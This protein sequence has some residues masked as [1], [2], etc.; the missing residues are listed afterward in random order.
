MSSSVS[1]TCEDWKVRVPLPLN[2]VVLV[3]AHGEGAEDPHRLV[4]EQA[5]GQEGKGRMIETVTELVVNFVW[6]HTEVLVLSIKHSTILEENYNYNQLVL[7]QW[8]S[9][10]II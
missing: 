2:G 9:C 5:R 3:A 8:H 4:L 10:G 7:Q 6:P 1:F